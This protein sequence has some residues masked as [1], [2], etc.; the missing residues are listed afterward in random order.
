MREGWSGDRYL[1]VYEDA[2]TSAA[3]DRYGLGA[4]FPGFILVGL[5]GWDDLL[6]RDA[7][8]RLFSVPAV[9]CIATHLTSFSEAVFSAPLRDD[10]RFTGRIKWYVRPV[11]FGGDPRDGDNLTWVSHE[12]HAQLVRWW[13]DQYR[14]LAPQTHV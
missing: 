5:C 13:N 9:P 7:Q 3:T 11:V 12:Q 14:S 2:E 6:V 4:S 8:G 1:I 10:A